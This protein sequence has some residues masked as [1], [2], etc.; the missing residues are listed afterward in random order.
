MN[1][2]HGYF[3]FPTVP[4]RTVIAFKKNVKYLRHSCMFLR[5]IKTAGSCICFLVSTDS[6][7]G[8]IQYETRNVICICM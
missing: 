3:I 4:N 7:F 2:L 1:F 5:F 6:F 8:E